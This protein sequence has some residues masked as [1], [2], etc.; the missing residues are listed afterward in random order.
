MTIELY[1]LIATGLLLFALAFVST[2]LY[3]KQVGNPALMGNRD[4]IPA[5]VGAARR[6]QR[7]HQNLL[8]NIVPFAIVILIAQALQLSTPLTQA[9][10]L[11]FLGARFVHAVVYIAGI[12]VVRTFAWLAG[13]AATIAIAFAILV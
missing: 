10:A 6:A 5:P 11:I 3:G 13:I 8:E 1:S 12:P 4:T 2:A 9:A 7:A